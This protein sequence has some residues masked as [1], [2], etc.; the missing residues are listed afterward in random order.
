MRLKGLR[1]LTA[2]YNLLTRLPESIGECVLLEKIR[3]VDNEITVMPHSLLQLW[4]RK[5]GALEELLVDGNPLVQP[6]ITAFQMG[7][8]D[9]ALRLFGEWVEESQEQPSETEEDQ[10]YKLLYRIYYNDYMFLLF[11]YL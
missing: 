11:F 9:Q 8:L 5:G 3:V 6:S 7:G 1:K 10:S 4:K 2:S